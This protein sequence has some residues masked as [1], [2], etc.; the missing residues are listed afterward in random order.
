MRDTG[1]ETLGLFILY[2]GIFK[3]FDNCQLSIKSM[4]LSIFFLNAVRL[5]FINERFIVSEEKKSVVAN[6][7]QNAFSYSHNAP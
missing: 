2:F 3:F 6:I 7:L 4:K 5:C 1:K